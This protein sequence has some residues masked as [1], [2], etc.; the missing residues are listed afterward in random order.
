VDAVS[1]SSFLAAGWLADSTQA[2]HQR[3][4]QGNALE[5][6]DKVRGVHEGIW[7]GL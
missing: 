3:Q 7:D 1:A 2:G 4:Y 5:L 6:I